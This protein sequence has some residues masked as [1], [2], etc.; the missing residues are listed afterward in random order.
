VLNDTLILDSYEEN[1][2]RL[3]HNASFGLWI[4]LNDIENKV[5]LKNLRHGTDFS[6]LEIK[7]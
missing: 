4:G 2:V 5:S 7:I 6:I 3:V 1:V